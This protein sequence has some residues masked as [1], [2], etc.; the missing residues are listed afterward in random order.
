MIFLHACL[1]QHFEAA[2]IQQMGRYLLPAP[3][4][5]AAS[6]RY[7]VSSVYR[8]IALGSILGMVLDLIII[9]LC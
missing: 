7:Y 3:R 6:S 9:A 4:L 2:E 1:I 8:R 5:H